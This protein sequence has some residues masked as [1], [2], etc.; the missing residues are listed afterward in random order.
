[1]RC[2]LI[3]LLLS[4]GVSFSHAASA[5]CPAVLH[6]QEIFVYPD[7]MKSHAEYGDY[8]IRIFDSR[9]CSGPRFK[10]PSGLEIRKAG[11]VIY[12]RTGWGFAIGYPLEEDQPPDAVKIKV[13]D[14]L[15]G[16]GVP[17]LLVSEWTGNAHCCY[18]FRVFQLG[19]EFKE[20]QELPLFDADESAFVRRPDVKGLVLDTADYSAFAYFPSSFA[21]SPAGRVFLSFHDGKFRPDAS[22]MR[23]DAP[24]T[25]E[26]VKC[27]AL[28][29]PSR[30]W[31]TSQPMGMWY[32]A[33]DLIYAGNE[34]Q[35][36]AFLNAAW[37]GSTADKRKYLDEYRSR[38]KKSIYYPDLESLQ[39]APVSTA[40]QKIDWTKQ[41]FEYLR[42]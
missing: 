25:G 14:D 15:T 4:L 31:K 42:G 23:A 41:C 40:G 30:D 34:T 22:L 27:A 33:T 35:A 37:G 38:L 19:P 28:F 17:D 16:D 3:L 36:W 39:K 29:T 32:Y 20:L 7:L 24:R 11:K 9:F 10:E 21:G 26:I 8:E 18:F 1:M 5:G 6:A 12:T 2:A 13:G